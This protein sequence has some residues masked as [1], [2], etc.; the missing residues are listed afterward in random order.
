VRPFHGAYFLEG[1]GVIGDGRMPFGLRG[2]DRIV[3]RGN[4][5]VVLRLTVTMAKR[6]LLA[7][8]DARRPSNRWR[9]TQVSSMAVCATRPRKRARS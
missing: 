1:V 3:D 7:S 6:R 9:A 4:V 5:D 8:L 2:H